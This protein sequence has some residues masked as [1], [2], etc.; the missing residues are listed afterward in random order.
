MNC[1]I[2]T[3]LLSPH[4]INLVEIKKIVFQIKHLYLKAR[5]RPKKLL[6]GLDKQII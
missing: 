3:V 4:N 6:I 5:N 2:E 1:L